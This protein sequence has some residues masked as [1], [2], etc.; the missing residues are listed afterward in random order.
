[1][2]APTPNKN[3]KQHFLNHNSPRDR[4][5]RM[6]DK[7]SISFM[8]RFG[9][10]RTLLRIIRIT[11]SLAIFILFV[12]VI[13]SMSV[14]FYFA[15]DLPNIK[16]LG[17][18]QPAVV[19]EVY[20][21]DGKKIGEFWI[22]R[23]LMANLNEMPDI[24]IK[25]FIASEDARFFE[26]EGV[27][28]A[29]IARALWEDAKAGGFVQGASTITQ[30]ITRSLLLSRE[31]HL[32]RKVREAIL[33]T[34]LERNLTK[35]QIL[36]LYLNEI[37]LGNR[38]YGVKAAAQNYFHKELKELTIAEAAMIAG[39]PQSP[40]DY[41][42][43]KNP[44]A[45]SQ[46]QKYVLSRML[47]QRFITQEEF[48][49]ARDET[50]TIY[51][52]TTDKEYNRKFTPYFTEHV[53]RML[54]EKYGEKTLYEGGLKIYTTVDTDM[55]NAA[56]LAVRNGIEQVDHRQNGWQGPLQ[57]GV[58]GEE[59]DALCAKV[60]NDAI[61]AAEDHFF[62]IP[63]LAE[64]LARK[65]GP[66][67]LQPNKNYSAVVVGN[68]KDLEIRVGNNVGIIPPANYAW[69]RGKINIGDVIEV[70]G[71]SESDQYKLVQTPKL[72]AALFSIELNTGY[73]R[74]MIGG[75]NYDNSEFNRATQSIRQ[76]G[77]SFKPF[78]YAAGLDKG[79]TYDTPVADT[80]VAYRVGTR[81]IW[82][83]KNYGGKYSGLGSFASHITASR[84]VPTVKIGH[85]IGLHYL[86]GFARKMGLTSPL[87]KYL[88]MSLGANGVYM[89]DLVTAYARFGSYGKE[90]QQVYITKIEDLHGNIL[91]QDENN[92]QTKLKT[93]EATESDEKAPT[94]ETAK[95]TESA[96]PEGYNTKLWEENQRWIEKDGLD[97][98]PDE[99][100]V[101]YGAAIPDG[102]VITP[103][104]A[105]LVTGLLQKV[106]QNGTAQKV[107]A[108][109]R[110]V[111]GKTG[112]TNDETDTWFVGYTPNLA[113]GVWVG[114]D[115][116]KKIGSGE[117][118]GRTAA[119]IFIEYMQK[120]LA[121]TPVAKFEAPPG[122][123][124]NKIASLTGGSAV[125][126]KGGLYKDANVEE[127]ATHRMD[128]RA[129]DFFEADFGGDF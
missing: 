57:T 4:S 92:L 74:A 104:T 46:R 112:T 52:A 118:G 14:Y 121:G 83:P 100:N 127:L 47:V 62:H 94:T 30:Q 29:G 58:E 27:D 24:L 2:V 7:K 6:S 97:L 18:Y 79:F 93:D 78:V 54:I 26:H 61:A 99:L 98:T 106:V 28:V 49:K 20:A 84:N 77:S 31:R 35:D 44:K 69:A 1:M 123:A 91:L 80:P 129:V 33:A 76:P 63:I 95:N 90:I 60:H 124:E 81:E 89:N 9:L 40:S 50:L 101:L 103:Q 3:E 12:G 42:P 39:L 37:F 119:P 53:R 125:Y 48:A 126:W 13:G 22:Q 107:R 113:A 108:L 71:T 116:L 128:D 105:Y 96:V 88:S 51:A 109:E 70:R 114:Y 41:N 15:R 73:V 82:S 66:T 8:E 21:Q 64:D 111:A 43:V 38:S 59:A 55:Y 45:A 19:S 16:S 34:R 67:P 120:V 87:N 5:T 32:S 75:Y 36:S 68:G 10:I 56:E 86:T 122:F 110:P 65:D 102:Y 117:Q 85:L 115:T 23:R 25:A 72:Q 17:D 11:V